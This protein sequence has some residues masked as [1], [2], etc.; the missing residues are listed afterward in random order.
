M[1]S[2]EPVRV[3][4]PAP[5]PSE[6]RPGTFTSRLEVALPGVVLMHFCAKPLTPPPKV[7]EKDNVYYYCSV[8]FLIYE[9]QVVVILEF[10]GL[11]RAIR[12]I[13]MGGIRRVLPTPKTRL[14]KTQTGP[15]IQACL[16]A[17][18]MYKRFTSYLGWFVDTTSFP[19]SIAHAHITLTPKLRHENRL[20]EHASVLFK[21]CLRS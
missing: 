19:C 6:A 3:V 18:I 16:D 1:F 15:F 14:K 7:W 5:L 4:G 13:Y 11:F 12:T 17:K 2:Q 21:A 9:C 10:I 8:I 20:Y